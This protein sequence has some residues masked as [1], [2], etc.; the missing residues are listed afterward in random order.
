MGIPAPT[1]AFFTGELCRWRPRPRG[2]SGCVTTPS[3]WKSGWRTRCSRE[4]TA[5]AGVPQKTMR[6]ATASLPFAG[7]FHF[8]DF[9]FDQIAF[10]QAEVGD[11]KN[12]IQM[13]DFVAESAREQPFTAHFK[14]FPGRVLRAHRHKLRTQDMPAESGQREAAFL[15]ALLA[16]CMHYFRIRADNLRLRVFPHAHINHSQALADSD[17][18]R[19]QSHS[20]CGVHRLEHICN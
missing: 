16:F 6:S 5:K 9:S 1:A 13:V 19:G 17:L 8:P 7:F 18:R 10:E 3:I 12:T 14:F 2:R 11:E 4:G 20:V 15:F